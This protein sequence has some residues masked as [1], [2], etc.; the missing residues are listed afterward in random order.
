MKAFCNAAGL[1][2]LEVL[3]NAYSSIQVLQKKNEVPPL[4]KFPW[5]HHTFQ[6]PVFFLCCGQTF[7]RQ[8]SCILNLYRIAMDDQHQSCVFSIPVFGILHTGAES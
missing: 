4:A 1:Y 2:L 8:F 5:M 7:D 3:W 6:I